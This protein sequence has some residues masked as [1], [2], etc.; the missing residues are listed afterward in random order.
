M[1]QYYNPRKTQGHPCLSPLYG[2]DSEQV[3]SSFD[4]AAYTGIPYVRKQIHKAASRSGCRF[5][6]VRTIVQ[7]LFRCNPKQPSAKVSQKRLAER[8]G[9]C[10]RTVRRIISG[11]R[12]VGV[13]HVIHNYRN[14]ENGRRRTAS[15]NILIPLVNWII[16]KASVFNSPSLQ[17]RESSQLMF[18]KG[19]SVKSFFIDTETGEI[20][21]E[22]PI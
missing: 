1:T 18:N 15:T 13:L 12:Q 3:L 14:T 5:R 11:L 7:E 9:M 20:I 2:I 19:T 21:E 10:E 8:A 17:A 22:N 16:R 4:I 6:D